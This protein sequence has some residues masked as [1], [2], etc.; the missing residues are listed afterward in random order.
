MRSALLS[1]RLAPA[2]AQLGA[3]RRIAFVQEHGR[4]DAVSTE[5]AEILAEFTPCGKDARGLEIADHHRP[6]HALAGAALFVAIG[7]ADLAAAVDRRARSHH[8]DAIWI[9]CA[10]RGQAACRLLDEG[11]KP[12]RHRRLDL[13]DEVARSLCQNRVPT[14]CDPLRTE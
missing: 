7:D 4:R 5:M 6:D 10:A 1:E 2:V 12:G 3:A 11:P 8:I 14:P 9:A 13:G